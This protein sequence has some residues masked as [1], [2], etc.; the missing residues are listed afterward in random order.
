MTLVI[1]AAG[2]GS[3]FGGMKQVT[4]V[5]PSGEFII[6]YS[7]YDAIKAG[8]DKIVFVIKRENLGIFRDTV[9]KR[10]KKHVKVEY[11]FHLPQAFF[12]TY[13]H[14]SLPPVRVRL[15]HFISILSD[16][17]RIGWLCR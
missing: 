5:G 11:A 10:V 2:M 9:G 16:K 1:L 8:F 12:P 15:K 13:P 4:P 14:G 7:C 3:R 17:D 6:D